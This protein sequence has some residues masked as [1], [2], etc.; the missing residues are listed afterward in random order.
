MTLPV[1]NVL[2][3]RFRLDPA[4]LDDFRLAVLDFPYKQE[5]DRFLN[6]MGQIAKLER[7][8]YPPYRQLNAALI[9]SAPM[10]VHAFEK[11]TPWNKHYERRMVSLVDANNEHFRPPSVEQVRRVVRDWAG[12]WV[13]RRFQEELE[14]ARGR[15]AWLRLR[16]GLQVEPEATWRYFNASELWEDRNANNGLGWKGIPNLLSAVLVARQ[17]EVTLTN[18]HGTPFRFHWR[19]AQ[20]SGQRLVVLSEPFVAEFTH[21]RG[22]RRGLVSYK[23][24]FSAQTQGGNSEPWIYLHTRLRRYVSKPVRTK[25]R[26]DVTIL[27]SM[28]ESSRIEGW[29]IAPTMVRLTAGGHPSD[30]HWTSSLPE[31]LRVINARPLADVGAIFANPQEFQEQDEHGDT[32]HVVYS[33]GMKPQHPANTGLGLHERSDLL[34]AVVAGMAGVLEPSSPVAVDKGSVLSTHGPTGIR[35]CRDDAGRL[36]LL[37]MLTHKDLDQRAGGIKL[38]HGTSEEE[39]KALKS[40]LTANA[41]RLASRG[42]PVRVLVCHRTSGSREPLREYVERALF[43]DDGNPLPEGLE[44][45]MV[46]VFSERGSKSSFPE[47]PDLT[48]LGRAERQD[49]RAKWKDDLR[50]AFR[51]KV[52]GWEDLFAKHRLTAGVTLAL[53]EM[54]G[55]AETAGVQD[56]WLKSAIRTAAD[57]S[58]VNTQMIYSVDQMALDPQR[59]L[60]KAVPQISRIKR[61]TSDLILRQTAFFYSPPMEIYEFAGLPSEI[62]SNLTVIGLYR[63]REQIRP[64]EWVDYPLAVKLAS[65]GAVDVVIPDYQT[66]KPWREIPYVE[67]GPAIGREFA[68]YRGKRDRQ[69][70]DYTDWENHRQIHNRLRAFAAEILNDDYSYP[71]L[72]LME[73]DGWRRRVFQSLHDANIYQGHI[74]LGPFGTL[75]TDKSPQLRIIRVRDEGTSNEIP[76]YVA[77]SESDWQ[78][79]SDAGDLDHMFGVADVRVDNG[80]PIYYSVGRR[81]KSV[82]PEH[83][84]QSINELYTFGEGAAVAY[85]HQQAVEFAPFFLQPGDNYLTWSRVAHFLRFS[86]AWET[87]NISLPYPIHLAKTLLQDRMSVLKR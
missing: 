12:E 47:Q 40:R 7:E 30:L 61:A 37:A 13:H 74:D 85:R 84:E 55:S 50:A 77:T 4:L 62:A 16:G 48:E 72:V 60:S 14:L 59:N 79:V 80:V 49:L 87:G 73:A 70:V 58:N 32:Y 11:S 10:L 43:G 21:G 51:Q 64:K 68:R 28:Y 6:T 19:L 66:G 57:R 39:D 23:L 38:M 15:E 65:T 67:A 33:E 17:Q 44:L 35:G 42:K 9:A 29:G 3:A 2:L 8:D 53:V 76:Q 36:S 31:L 86:P 63:H 34:A 27:L 56:S 75:T 20:E 81:P 78:D 46:P 5:F 1:S 26:A 52:I 22:T 83:K 24:E 25:S 69:L 82:S 45:C 18:R 54:D 71:T 41:L